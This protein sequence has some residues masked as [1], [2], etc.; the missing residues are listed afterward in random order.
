MGRQRNRIWWIVFFVG[1]AITIL[2]TYLGLFNGNPIGRT[3]TDVGILILWTSYYMPSLLRTGKKWKP[4][5]AW[6]GNLIALFL[7]LFGYFFRGSVAGNI[8]GYVGFPV[9]IVTWIITRLDE[10]VC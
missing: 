7:I 5:V 4:I 9:V 2:G 8:M 3:V 1:L 6:C 10:S